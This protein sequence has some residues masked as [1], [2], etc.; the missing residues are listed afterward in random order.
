[1]NSDVKGSL[2]GIVREVWLIHM[3]A[4]RDFLLERAI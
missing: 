3:Y 2:D 4:P 1:M